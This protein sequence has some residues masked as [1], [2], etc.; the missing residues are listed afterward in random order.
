MH[1]CYT[2]TVTPLKSGTDDN[3]LSSIPV[4][5]RLSCNRTTE[6]EKNNFIEIDIQTSPTLLDNSGLQ[7]N[8]SSTLDETLQRSLKSP[9]SKDEERVH[10]HLTK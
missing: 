4:D 5:Q 2:T 3:P 6:S 8:T 7:E 9:L 10:T 1:N